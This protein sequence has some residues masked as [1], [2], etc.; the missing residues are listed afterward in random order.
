MHSHKWQ[1]SLPRKMHYRYDAN[2]YAAYNKVVSG[3][4][5]NADTQQGA[6]L[7]E[8]LYIL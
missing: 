7:M 5:Y 6:Q 8:L 1:L 3:R 2:L 4:R